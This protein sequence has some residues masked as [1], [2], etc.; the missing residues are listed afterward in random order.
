MKR[1]LPN[2]ITLL[3]LACGTAAIVLSLEGHWQ[4]QLQ[5][6]ISWM[7]LRLVS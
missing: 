7:G 3:N 6:L 2:L 4:L 5:Y 1:H